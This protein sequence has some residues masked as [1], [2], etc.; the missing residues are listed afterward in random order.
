M[1]CVGSCYTEGVL[2]PVSGTEHPLSSDGLAQDPSLRERIEDLT[3]G[4]LLS[5]TT[6]I[7]DS[8][9]YRVVDSTHVAPGSNRPMYID[10]LGGLSDG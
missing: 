8:R 10:H 9:T 5:R 1:H 2:S 4:S 7:F 6:V 3:R